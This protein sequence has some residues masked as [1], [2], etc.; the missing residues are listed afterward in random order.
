VAGEQL[1]GGR[2]PSPVFLIAQVRAHGDEH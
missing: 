1:A 2:N